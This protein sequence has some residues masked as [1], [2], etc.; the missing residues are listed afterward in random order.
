MCVYRERNLEALF[1]EAI[2]RKSEDR[3]SESICTKMS[4]DQTLETESLRSTKK[5]F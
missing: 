4:I 1:D 2:A 3:R 5:L